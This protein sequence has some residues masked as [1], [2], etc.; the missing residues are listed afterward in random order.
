MLLAGVCHHLCAVAFG[1]HHERAAIL[2]ELVSV[3]VHA[4]CRG[5]SHG[6]ARHAL[7]CLCRSCIEYGVVLEVVRHS[8]AIVQTRLNLGVGYVSRHYYST[9]EA[10]AG[11]DGIF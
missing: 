3:G 7:R 6:A 9:V 5:R 1:Y 4:V 8:L 11:G 2:L 10:H